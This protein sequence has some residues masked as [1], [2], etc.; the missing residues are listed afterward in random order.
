MISKPNDK[1]RF[2]QK[3]I[4]LINLKNNTKHSTLRMKTSHEKSQRKIPTTQAEKKCFT[5]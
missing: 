3:Q 5:Y 2:H 1:I 4:N